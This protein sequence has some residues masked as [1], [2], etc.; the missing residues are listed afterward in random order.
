VNSEELTW[1]RGGKEAQLNSARQRLTDA[2]GVWSSK[3]RR[4]KN[5]EKG[6]VGI[7]LTSD[8]QKR[9]AEKRE[10]SSGSPGLKDKG[11]KNHA[12]KGGRQS[13]ADSTSRRETRK[14]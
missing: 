1:G 7:R 5:K 6:G 14:N 9:F 8:I 4:G 10:V 3:N 11:R 13:T 12:G 2:K